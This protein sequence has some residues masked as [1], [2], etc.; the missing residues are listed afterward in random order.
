MSVTSQAIQEIRAMVESGELQPGDRLPPEQELADHLGISRGSLREAVRA[1]SQIQILDVRRGDGTYVASLAPSELLSSLSLVMEVLQARGQEEVVEV[2][3]LLLPPAMALAAQR[4][5]DE[6]IAELREIVDRGDEA[7]DPDEIV[8]LHHRFQSVLAR[9]TGNETLAAILDA[10]QIRGA[11]ARRTWL[12]AEPGNQSRGV[13]HERVLLDAIERRDVEMA[14]TIAALQ[15]ETR[16]RFLDGL[17]TR[18]IEDQ[19]S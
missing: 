11:K 3:R 7:T 4:A 5:T 9:S 14:R 13:A 2:R 12:F 18:A 15:V 8:D 10:L 6:Q 16:Q 19:P 1:L 17:K